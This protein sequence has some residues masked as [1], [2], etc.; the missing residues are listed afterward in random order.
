LLVDD[1]ADARATI[2]ELLETNGHTVTEAA[3]GQEALNLL[4]SLNAPHF[5]LIVLDL[6]MPVMDGWQFLK[7]LGNYVRLAHIPVLI[8]SAHT[9]RLEDA[10]RKRVAG[11]LQAPYE[12]DQ[13]LGLVN[14]CITPSWPPK[15]A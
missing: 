15:S 13:L 2:R 1:Y 9:E 14:G 11:C 10:E 8:V 5:S 7:L 4:V 12:L 6:Q 3:N